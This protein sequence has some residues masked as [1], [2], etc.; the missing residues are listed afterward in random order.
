MH[1]RVASHVHT[2]IHVQYI[3]LYYIILYRY[4]HVC[5]RVF[6]QPPYLTRKPIYAIAYTRTICSN[7]QNAYSERRKTKICNNGGDV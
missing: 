5:M 7:Q 4:R 6:A 3:V 2:F 1:T